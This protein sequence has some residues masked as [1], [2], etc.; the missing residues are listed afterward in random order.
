MVKG[1][2]SSSNIVVEQTCSCKLFVSVPHFE[3]AQ[4]PLPSTENKVLE[5]IT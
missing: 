1:K 4:D 2:T 5:L 3:M